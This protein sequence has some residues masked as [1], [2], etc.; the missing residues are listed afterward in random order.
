MK[1]NLIALAMVLAGAQA[2]ACGELT[3][4]DAWVRLA[5]PNAPVMAGYLTLTTTSDESV[6]VTGASSSAFERV[7]LHDMT[8]ENGVM[9]MRKLDQ[10]EI[11]AGGKV[12]LAPGGMHLMLIGPK[13][14]FAVGDSVEV[15][16]RLCAAA[17]EVVSFVVR[18]AAPESKSEH[19]DHQHRH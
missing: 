16:L 8:H 14:A 9:K 12:E 7:E 13:R 11:A 10:I 18:E 6:S 5:P 2:Q 19:E 4:T 17:D 1:L 3:V 15:T